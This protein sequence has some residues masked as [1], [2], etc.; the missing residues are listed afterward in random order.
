[1][2]SFKNEPCV[3]IK[4]TKGIFN[5]NSERIYKRRERMQGIWRIIENL[6]HI[7]G[8]VF[9]LLHSMSICTHKYK[10]N[11]KY[12]KHKVFSRAI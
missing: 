7:K 5:V 4:S 11:I 12:C 6:Q 9:F 3:V 2:S 10:I 1:M 8:T